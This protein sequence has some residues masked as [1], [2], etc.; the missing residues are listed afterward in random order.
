[1][2]LSIEIKQLK[3]KARLGIL[4]QE[5]QASQNLFIDFKAEIIP[6]NWPVDALDASLSYAKIHEI[7][8]EITLSR[9]WDLLEELAEAIRLKL[10]SFEQ[11]KSAEISL[12]KPDIIKNCKF[13]GIKLC[14]EG[15]TNP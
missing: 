13:V 11:I 12:Q 10:D 9:H 5:K 14:W 15:C 6:K 1:M 7:L 4:P 3:I 2:K 8:C